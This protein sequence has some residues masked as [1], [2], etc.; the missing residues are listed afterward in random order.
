MNDFP[1][2]ITPDDLFK[3]EWLHT[4]KL[5][6]D[7][8]KIAYV[9]SHIEEKNE[10]KK[11]KEDKEY[12]TIYLYDLNTDTSR[13]MTSGKYKDG[14]PVWSPDGKTIA[15][16][17]D[18]DE[19]PQ[20]YL[21]P[22]DGGEAQQLTKLE[23]GASSPVWSPDGTNIAFTAGRDWG[24]KKPDRSKD[25]YRVI[26]NVWRFDAIGDLEMSTQ[27]V[28]VVNVD[29]GQPRQLTDSPTLDGSL[30]WS[31]DGSQLLYLSMAHPENFAFF[32][33]SVTLIDLE[34]NGEIIIPPTWGG[35]ND[36]EWLP[37][38][39]HI[40]F[41]GSPDDGSP[42]GT[43]S[44]LYV[45]NINTREIVNRTS[46]YELFI[47]GGLEGR[48]PV[49]PPYV[50]KIT[51]DGQTLYARVQVGGTVGIYK[52]ALDG[53]ENAEEVIGGER[54]CILLDVVGDKILYSVDD[55]NTPPNLYIA[56][57]DGSDERQLTELNKNRFNNIDP[58]KVE[59]LEFK[60]SDGADV[61]GWYVKPNNGA[62]APYPT[63]LWIHGGPH[64]AQGNRFAFDTWMLAGAGYGVM[65]VNHRASTGYGNDFSTAIKGDWGNL[66]YNDLMNG[67]DY[68][69]DKKLADP[70]KLGVCGISGGGNLS[71]WIVGNT[72][73]FK[74]A[75]PQN[76]VT[77]WVSFYGVSDIG[78]WFSV[79]ELGGHPHE[80]PEIYRK[81][82]PITYAHNCKTP[83]LMIQCEHDW[84][85]PNEQSEQFYTVL[86]ANGCTVEMLR[87]PNSSHGGSIRGP[88]SVRKSHVNATLNW[89]N[90]Y[91]LGIEPE[92][93]EEEGENGDK[94]GEKSAP[95]E[96]NNGTA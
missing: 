49:I 14:N 56:N 96:E 88:L 68:A 60:G 55:I 35:I 5:S 83:T 84:R 29:G 2:V 50:T 26:R 85:C 81:C 38:G 93:E 76:P 8:T 42:I 75:I 82:S 69:I 91:I 62:K 18:R 87:H 54:T 22:V 31:P 37:D 45:M 34:G 23:Q 9:V 74:A 78:V 6:P 53:D 7:G 28:Y 24:E 21:L 4:G 79:E 59:K 41:V 52:F 3:F 86:K 39:K 10:K 73:R 40:A 13:K 67:V 57:I 77:N 12:T 27:N 71:T 11:R 89:F 90:K 19:K 16:I 17:S 48:I 30:A 33:P 58:L 47:G 65:F 61:E 51:D 36:P 44:H 20:I 92:S 46:N 70:D 72:D 32:F 80:I 94:N 64:G 25:P 15:F 1:R 43:N 63:I 66:D 95:A